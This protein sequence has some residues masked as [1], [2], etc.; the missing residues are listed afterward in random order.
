MC[1]G[2]LHF[3]KASNVSIWL[4]CCLRHPEIFRAH[5]MWSFEDVQGSSQDDSFRCARSCTQK[6]SDT[7]APLKENSCPTFS[8]AEHFQLPDLQNYILFVLGW[9]HECRPLGRGGAGFA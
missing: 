5:K 8:C 7:T 2:A 6:W 9:V 3:L 4:H 1:T